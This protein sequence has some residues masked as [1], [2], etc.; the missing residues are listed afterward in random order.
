MFSLT[1][2]LI[3]F[4]VSLLKSSGSAKRVGVT[5][6]YIRVTQYEP[7]FL[8]KSCSVQLGVIEYKGFPDEVS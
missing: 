5:L 2:F 6:I 3:I 1:F 8:S 4:L 7:T